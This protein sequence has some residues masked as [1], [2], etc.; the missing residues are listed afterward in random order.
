LV[1]RPLLDSS[2]CAITLFT[3]G[4]PLQEGK[5]NMKNDDKNHYTQSE[6][7][8]LLKAQGLRW[9]D[10]TKWMSGQT[11]PIIDGEV[12]FYKHDADR[13]LYQG[14]KNATIIDW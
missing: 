3:G 7:K 5:N 10:F 11:A 2:G 8:A 13:F 14:G 4:T 9:A 12:C 6:I 1:A